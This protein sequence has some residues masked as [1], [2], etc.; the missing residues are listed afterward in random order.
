MQAGCDKIASIIKDYRQGEIAELGAPHVR[1]WINQFPQAMR[2]PLLDE[3]AH[4][5]S[6]TYIDR[7][8]VKRFLK[9]VATNDKLVGDDAPAYWKG[10][11][12]LR[13]QRAGNSQRDML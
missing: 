1:L 5:L 4:I 8:T 2:E 7:A 3:T 11:H 10:V 12:F 13:L 9:G 6:K